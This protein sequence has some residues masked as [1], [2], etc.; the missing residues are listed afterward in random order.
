MYNSTYSYGL[1]KP[2]SFENPNNSETN[3]LPS[4]EAYSDVEAPKLVIDTV[5]EDKE[6]KTDQTR[7]EHSNF[8]W[9]MLRRISLSNK[10]DKA[11]LMTVKTYN[12]KPYVDIR[13]HFKQG[14]SSRWIPTKQGVCLTID[15]FKAVIRNGRV[16]METLKERQTT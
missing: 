8:G 5:D 6:D 9:N 4:F 14:V 11:L 12:Q 3:E 1:V 7:P 16:V 2:S 13:K 10:D 15:E